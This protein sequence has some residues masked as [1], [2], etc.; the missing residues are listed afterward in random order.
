MEEI[1]QYCGTKLSH[2]SEIDPVT[3]QLFTE[4]AHSLFHDG[5]TLIKI[6]FLLPLA[7][8]TIVRNPDKKEFV[9]EQDS[10]RSGE[11]TII[12]KSGEAVIIV[13]LF[14]REK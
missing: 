10:N 5:I 4:I 2:L 7:K 6:G 12:I 9:P 8:H 13:P 14:R 11:T 3:E 1:Q